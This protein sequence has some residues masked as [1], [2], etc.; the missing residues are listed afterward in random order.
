MQPISM[1]LLCKGLLIV[2]AALDFAWC[3]QT[4]L[5]LL[6]VLVSQCWL[7][8]G[9]V[10]I[11]V[12]PVRRSL[13][14]ILGLVLVPV[15]SLQKWSRCLFLGSLVDIWHPPAWLGRENVLCGRSHPVPRTLVITAKVASSDTPS[16]VT[17]PY[18]GCYWG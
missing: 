1:L 14:E 4:M 15:Y 9:P 7:L 3:L 8:F 18:L 11:N 12:S 6:R 17:Q 5:L 13:I 16:E 10:D 2:L